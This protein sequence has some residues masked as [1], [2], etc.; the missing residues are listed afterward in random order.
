MNPRKHISVSKKILPAGS[1]PRRGLDIF[2]PLLFIETLNFH[3][4]QTYY[5]R[6]TPFAMKILIWNIMHGGGRRAPTIVEYVRSGSPDILILTEFRGTPP[7]REIASRIEELGLPHQ[8]NTA[9]KNHPA[10]NAL[11]LASRW[12]LKRIHWKRSPEPVERRLLAHVRAPKPIAVAAVHVPNRVSG[13]KYPFLD[14]LRDLTR[15]WRGGGALMAGD[16]NTGR[17]GEDESVKCFN[18]REDDFMT[19]MSETGW[20]DAYRSVHGPKRAYTWRAPGGGG[21]FRLDHAFINR[22]AR[23]RLLDARI[24]WPPGNP[25]PPSDHAALWITLKD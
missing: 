9:S 18:R 3:S 14:A 7:S 6:Y 21:S 19:T 23:K 4:R 13:I 25:K 12:P 11:L 16:F 17:I 15:R 2:R 22:S 10:K 1:A 20:A 5:Y 24:D 8:L